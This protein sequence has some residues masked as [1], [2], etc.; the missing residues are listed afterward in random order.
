MLKTRDLGRTTSVRR[1]TQTAVD[2]YKRG[3]VCSGCFYSDF[4]KESPQ[5]CQMK[6][7]VLELVRVLGRPNVEP[8]DAIIGS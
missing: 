2:C 7:T 5:R 3:C 1:W 4:F 6:A 8:L